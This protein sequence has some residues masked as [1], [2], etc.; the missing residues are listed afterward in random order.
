MNKILLVITMLLM[1]LTLPAYCQNN[2]EKHATQTIEGVVTSLDWVGAMIV[3][4]GITVSVPSNADIHK[5]LNRIGLNAIHVRDS[6]RVTY[7]D[8][9]SGLHKAVTI[10][11]QCSGDCPV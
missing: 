3:V 1:C 9:P 6:V 11:V 7:Y 10:E 5:G 2:S 4:N 8:V